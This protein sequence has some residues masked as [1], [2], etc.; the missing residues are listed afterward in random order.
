MKKI[1]VWFLM[2]SL[3]GLPGQVYAEKKG[4]EIIIQKREGLKVRGELI[5]VKENAL[6][7]M[8]KKSGTDVSVEVDQIKSVV[9]VKKSKPNYVFFGGLLVGSAL[10]GYLGVTLYGSGEEA[11]AVMLGALGAAAFAS[12]GGLL[13]GGTSSDE[14]IS[15]EGK[16]D[17]QIQD[18]LKKLRN[19][20]RVKNLQ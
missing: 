17:S 8:E 13:F 1:L 9:L 6:L 18:I 5:S 2:L 12:L 4:A 19:A 7:L 14:A 20:A 16:T 3:L 11:L 15:F 10:G